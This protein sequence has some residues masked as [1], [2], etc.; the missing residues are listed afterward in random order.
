[1]TDEVRY[2]QLILTT[3]QVGLLAVAA[4][5]ARLASDN[6]IEQGQLGALMDFLYYVDAQPEGF[7]VTDSGMRRSINKRIARVKGPAQPTPNKRKRAQLR[8]QGAQKRTRAQKRVEA[9]V[10]NQAREAA[11]EAQAIEAGLEARA[12][13]ESLGIVLPE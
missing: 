8:S 3:S 9:A 11:L 13:A 6:E 7:P 10:F 5:N 12:R 4:G 2:V 1:M